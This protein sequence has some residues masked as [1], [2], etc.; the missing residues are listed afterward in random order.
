M[1]NAIIDA[2]SAALDKEFGDGCMICA[3]ETEP[4]AEKSCFFISCINSAERPLPGKRYSRTNQ[5]C[6]RY[7]P[8]G[9]KK[10]WECNGAAERMRQCLEYITVQGTDRPIRGTK[11]NYEVADGVLN[12]FVNYDCFVRRVVQQER[13]EQLEKKNGVKGGD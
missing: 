5:F 3:E 11:M 10:Q 8:A 1:T 6:I 9:S 4:G 12:F 13:M 2:V 7:I